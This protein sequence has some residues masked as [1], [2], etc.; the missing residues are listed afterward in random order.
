[1]KYRTLEGNLKRK[2][3]NSNEVRKNVNVSD[4]CLKQKTKIN[5]SQTN[6]GKKN[7]RDDRKRNTEQNNLKKKQN[8]SSFFQQ[9][10]E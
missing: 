3:S 1:M 8:L 7:K 6:H 9:Y 4:K 2:N 5:V 10:S